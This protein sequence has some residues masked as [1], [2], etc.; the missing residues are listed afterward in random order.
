MVTIIPAVLQLNKETLESEIERMSMISPFLHIDVTGALVDGEAVTFDA[1]ALEE[2]LS[3]DILG[4]QYQVHFM[5]TPDELRQW[6]PPLLDC[7]TVSAMIIHHEI[8][9]AEVLSFAEMV[10]S[11]NKS[12][13]VAINPDTAVDVVDEYIGQV[14]GVMVMGVVPGAQGNPFEASTFDRVAELHRKFPQLSITVDGAVSLED[15][16]AQKLAKSG[17]ESLVV[18][19]K[20]RDARD[21]QAVYDAFA[22][23]VNQ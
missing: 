19:S 7:D 18:G 9:S 5:L 14:D 20:I 16:R 15:E 6:I 23:A 1:G 17:A 10:R 11:N 8:G 12:V 22:A 4:L 21:P 3:N 13:I 2:V